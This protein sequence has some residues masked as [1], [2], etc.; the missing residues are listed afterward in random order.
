[1]GTRVARRK[2][3]GK[4]LPA[5]LDRI[6]LTV[7]GDAPLAGY[8]GDEDPG[9]MDWH[10]EATLTVFPQED[11]EPAGWW[12]QE[13]AVLE[14]AVAGDGLKLT[15]LQAAG[16]LVDLSRV[17]NVYD[18][19]DARSA[20]YEVFSPMFEGPGS[21]ELAGE[22]Q[23]EL[24][25]Y[26]SQ[27]VLVDRVWL[28][29]AWRGHGAGRLLTGRL[30]GW[31]CPDPVVVALMPSPI[32]LDEKQQDDEAAFSQEMAKVRRTW[33]SVGFRPFGKDIMIM[34]PAMAHHEEAVNKLARKL[35]LPQ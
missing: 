5:P 18:A 8:G 27:V 12:K 1:M 3:P 13:G 24:A 20:D 25:S 30:L 21:P 31:V 33:K 32:A 9:V 4:P 2:V 28:A 6:Q 35:G 14:T 34:D 15:I 23:D 17:R 29:P 11:D 16:L 7:G 19:L 22:L 26:S 10:G